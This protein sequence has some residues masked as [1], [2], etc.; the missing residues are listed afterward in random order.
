MLQET[1]HQ[2]RSYTNVTQRRLE[3]VY[4]PDGTQAFVNGLPL[5]RE[6]VI[7]D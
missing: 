2:V 1:A 3:P 5:R 4:N 6:V 7:L